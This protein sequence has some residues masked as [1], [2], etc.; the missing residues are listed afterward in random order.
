MCLTLTGAQAKHNLFRRLGWRKFVAT[1]QGALNQALSG[2]SL[3]LSQLGP[4]T[5]AQPYT[6]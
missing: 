4:L 6:N 3:I 1:K 2:P 5:N